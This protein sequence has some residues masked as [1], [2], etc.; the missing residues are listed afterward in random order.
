MTPL[1]EQFKTLMKDYKEVQ[2]S[3]YGLDPEIDKKLDSLSHQ[4]EAFYS[5]LQSHFKE[6]HRLLN[7][8][9]TLKADDDKNHEKY[10]LLWQQY[11]EI[12]NGE[13]TKM[14]EGDK[15]LFLAR[16]RSIY[17]ENWDDLDEVSHNMLATALYLQDL[18]REISIDDYSPV[19][20]EFCRV[21]ENEIKKKIFDPFISFDNNED[22]NDAG[23]PY[24]EIVS[25]LKSIKEKGYSFISLKSMLLCLQELNDRRK[26]C[27]L[28]QSLSSFLDKNHWKKGRLI[29]AKFTKNSIKYTEEYRNPAAHP[30]I[31]NQND[32]E[33]C[34]SQTNQLVR[35]F[36][37]CAPSYS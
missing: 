5:E 20:I 13:F 18:C 11:N 1:I 22:I 24:S 30:N 9:R 23:F 12:L 10:D 2:S 26:S 29:D 3:V 6:Y 15:A 36:I 28:S 25:A 35:Y 17:L 7:E 31:M 8:M 16:S 37:S 4:G 19:I 27:G 32:A 33:K 14:T 34:N 21:F